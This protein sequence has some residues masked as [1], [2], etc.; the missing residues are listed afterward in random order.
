MWTDTTPD[1]C[2]ILT[3]HYS[4]YAE[5]LASSRS[6]DSVLRTTWLWWT[7]PGYCWFSI[8]GSHPSWWDHSASCSPHRNE[9]PHSSSKQAQEAKT[10][11]YLTPLLLLILTCWSLSY[12][13]QP[14]W[15]AGDWKRAY[16]LDWNCQ[17]RCSCRLCPFTHSCDSSLWN[18]TG[19]QWLI[20]PASWLL[21]H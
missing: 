3:S 14:A 16:R 17:C 11:E 7:Y 15:Q 1:L 5:P 6:T 8:V 19:T 2:W 20:P 9:G 10:K 18:F 12:S 4:Q 13:F 21:W